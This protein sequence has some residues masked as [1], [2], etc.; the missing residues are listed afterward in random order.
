MVIA[1]HLKKRYGDRVSVEYHD[2]ARESEKAAYPALVDLIAEKSPA[3]PLVEIDGQVVMAG[4]VDFWAIV[5]AIEAKASIVEA[6]SSAPAP[7]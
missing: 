2:L 1:S 5:E 7:R 3:L 4:R 6:A